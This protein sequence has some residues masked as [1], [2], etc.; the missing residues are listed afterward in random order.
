M[1]FGIWNA[2]IAPSAVLEKSYGIV[3][4]IWYPMD[5]RNSPPPEK[6][7]GL[8][9]QNI[10]PGEVKKL[11]STEKLDASTTLIMT[12]GV[13]QYPTRWGNEF[14]KRGFRWWYVPH[15]MLEPWSMNQKRLK[16]EIYF[17]LVENRLIK[18]AEL[19]RAVGRPEKI[20]LE[21]LVGRE[22]SLIP[23]GINP[24]ETKIEKT[25]NTSRKYLFMSRLHHKKGIIPLVKAWLGS[26]V[27][28]NPAFELIVAGPDDGEKSS[29]LDILKQNPSANIRYVGAVYGEEK[30]RLLSDSHFFLLPSQSEGFPTSVLEAMQHGV[31]PVITE[32]CNFP[33]AFES[34]VAIKTGLTEEKIR[35]TLNKTANF[36]E[37]E[38]K[39]QSALARAF[40]EERYSMEVIGGMIFEVMG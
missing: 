11:I 36:S 9:L 16:K 30:L 1:N 5:D 8:A 40:V 19:I 38:L 26:S 27:S 20:N 13:W 34:G 37:E 17:R 23:N 15:G 24:S 2:A 18:T 35:E 4:E 7:K 14:A 3:S 21:K 33:E 32:G 39:K 12:H 29:L 25:Y 22:V 31:L 10:S 6:I 28:Q